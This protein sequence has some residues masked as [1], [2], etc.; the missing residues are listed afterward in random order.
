MVSRLR[1]VSAEGE[2]CVEASEGERVGEGEVFARG[3]GAGLAGDDVEVEGGV[4][5]GYACGIGKAG[6]F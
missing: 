2:D 1:L 6:G 3:E 5:L 4:D